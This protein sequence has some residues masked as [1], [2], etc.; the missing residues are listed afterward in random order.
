MLVANQRLYIDGTDMSRLS[1]L[2]LA[3]ILMVFVVI[4]WFW[5]IFNFGKELNRVYYGTISELE[6]LISKYVEKLKKNI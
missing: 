3:F 6:E 4:S 1:A 5:K 2:N